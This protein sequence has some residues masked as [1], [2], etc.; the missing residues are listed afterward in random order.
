MSPADFDAYLTVARRH[1]VMSLGLEVPVVDAITKVTTMAKLSVTL[2][3]DMTLVAGGE[4]PEPG[5]WKEWKGPEA[6]DSMGDDE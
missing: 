3:P 4:E 1:N 6:L 2:G 5:S